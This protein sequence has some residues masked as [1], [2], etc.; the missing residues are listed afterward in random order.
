MLAPEQLRVSIRYAGGRQT[1]DVG[2]IINC[3]GPETDPTFSTNSLLQSLLDDGTARADRT[4][5]GLSVDAENRIVSASGKSQDG[6]YAVGAL[7]RGT[8][9]EVTA[10]PDLRSQTNALAQRLLHEYELQRLVP[11]GAETN[12]S[13]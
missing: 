8:H 3:T 10:I 5:L 4:R 13:H 12:V 1:I 2:R 7:T 11:A 9:W 6:L